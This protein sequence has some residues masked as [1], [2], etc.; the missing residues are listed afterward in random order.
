MTEA[1]YFSDATSHEEMVEYFVDKRLER[2]QFQ[3]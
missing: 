2:T 1:E 3:S